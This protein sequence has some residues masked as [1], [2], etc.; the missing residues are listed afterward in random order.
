MIIILIIITMIIICP[1]NSPNPPLQ[2]AN[3]ATHHSN[4]PPLRN[5]DCLTHLSIELSK[6][7]PAVCQPRHPLITT[8]PLPN[9]DFPSTHQPSHLP[10]K[11]TANQTTPFPPQLKLSIQLTT[12][13]PSSQPSKLLTDQGGHDQWSECETLKS[14]LTTAQ[15]VTSLYSAVPLATCRTLFPH[16]KKNQHKG[17]TSES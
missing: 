6:P 13:Q 12:L 10:M 17:R 1:S 9:P 11:L 2:S 8:H 15:K 4:H 14:E 5:S 7:N 16:F 3:Q